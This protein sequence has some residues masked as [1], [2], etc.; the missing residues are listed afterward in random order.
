MS[1]YFSYSN[2]KTGRS[3]S[4]KSDLSFALSVLSEAIDSNSSN[5]GNDYEYFN[6]GECFADFDMVEE[7]E[8]G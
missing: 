8:E 3:V 1:D 5:I 6:Q 7:F 4:K 2:E